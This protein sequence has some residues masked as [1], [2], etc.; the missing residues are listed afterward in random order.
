MNDYIKENDTS[1]HQHFHIVANRIN[2]EGK[3]SVSDSNSYRRMSEFFRKMELKYQLQQTL[4]P[5]V[6][7][8]KNQ[9]LIPRNDKRKTTMKERI[10]EQVYQ[11]KSV[12]E[13]MER[14]KYLGVDTIKSRGISFIDDK[15]VKLKGSEIGFSLAKV[16]KIIQRNNQQRE[17]TTFIELSQ[18][19]RKI[20]R[21]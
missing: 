14:L 4:S 8:P 11:S 5:R 13:F 2:F 6:F 10:E 9:R 19:R 18:R 17:E 7:L 3:T 15:G 1:S 20:S 21:N 12:D 16:E